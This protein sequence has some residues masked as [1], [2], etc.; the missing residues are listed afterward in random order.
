MSHIPSLYRGDTELETLPLA[1]T[2]CIS[3]DLWVRCE[4]IVMVTS[5]V[6][7]SQVFMTVRSTPTSSIYETKLTY[8]VY[9]CM[10]QSPFWEA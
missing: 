8:Y 4:I 6:R 9:M 2:C 1:L 5:C 3:V 10:E 7:N